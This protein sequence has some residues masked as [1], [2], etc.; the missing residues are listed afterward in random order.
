MKK[1]NNRYVLESLVFA[2]GK[3]IKIKKLS[4][5]TKL[6]DKEVK[7]EL[8][9]LNNEY[10][11]TMRGIRL[12]AKDETVQMVTNPEYGKQT[13]GLVTEDLQED[14]SKV[15]LETLSI[16]AYREPI[17]RAE[18]ELIRGVNC[19]YILR[20]LMIRGLIEKARSEKDSRKT[21]YQVSLKFLRHLGVSTV[22]ELPDYE[23][24]S[25]EMLIKSEE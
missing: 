20:N 10:K 13:Q 17:T 12:L 8:N 22:K 14:L 21:I 7:S 23:E 16:I 3:P 9:E 18:I 24:L 6:S 1:V 4:Q 2:S 25:K 5:I 19:I 11:E 15:A